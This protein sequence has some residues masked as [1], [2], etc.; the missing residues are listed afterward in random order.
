[1]HLADTALLIWPYF[2]DEKI[3]LHE[4]KKVTGTIPKTMSI[5][6]QFF[7]VQSWRDVL[8]RTMNTIADLEP[9]KF[10][11]IMQQYP[12][13]VGRDKKKF[14]ETGETIKRTMKRVLCLR[15]TRSVEPKKVQAVKRKAPKKDKKTP[16]PEPPLLVGCFF[17]I[18]S[19]SA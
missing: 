14:R 5:L 7:E 18:S 10:G 16:S 8:E 19:R 13:S 11:L 12:R 17:I 9:E 1:M 6:G 2:G 3:E 15:E 4:Q